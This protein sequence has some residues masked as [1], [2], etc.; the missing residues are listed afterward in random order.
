MSSCKKPAYAIVGLGADGLAIA[1]E[2]GLKGIPCIVADLPANA[3]R[4]QAIEAQSGIIC[5]S[6]TD[7]L[8]GGTG[9]HLAPVRDVTVDLRAAA[10][11]ADVV[12]VTVEPTHLE[13]V[14]THL[15]DGLRD[16]HIVILC[17]GGVGGPL[18]AHKIAADHGVSGALLGQISKPYANRLEESGVV[19]IGEKKKAVPLGVF[20]AIRSA[21]VLARLQDDFPQLRAGAN[22]IASGLN[23]A[24]IGLHPLPMIMNI[25]KIEQLGA[26]R[27]D[28]YD[29]TPTVGKVI[30]AVDAERQAILK[31]LG[32]ET[33]SFIGVLTRSFGVTGA[34]FHEAVHKV[35]SYK[36]A[37]S[38]P[39]IKHRYLTE[40]VPT[41][42]VPAASIGA[43]LGV[44][45]PLLDGVVA[46][47]SAMIGEDYRKTG[48]N[49]EKLGL[50]GLN[51]AEIIHFIETG[52][53]ADTVPRPD[54]AEA[55]H[56]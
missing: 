44:D 23:R 3:A 41:Q 14:L 29:I 7:A 32:H 47:A 36:G 30:E 39:Q 48:W 54:A 27:Y 35:E 50:S 5:R 16:D 10:E 33:G 1:A 9:E 24:G 46:F 38:P 52:E 20:P 45:T 12:V 55:A 31:A 4:V 22:I 42:V 56:P 26:Y 17:P 49:L 11:N 40:D 15:A 18:I 51:P 53:R 34:T 43:A 8:P 2:L 6:E 21:E 25:V 19:R 13:N 28:G 37:N